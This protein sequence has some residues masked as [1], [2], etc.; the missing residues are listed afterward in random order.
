VFLGCFK[1]F[2]IFIGPTLQPCMHI[3]RRRRR[4]VPTCKFS[5]ERHSRYV[6]GSGQ[7]GMFMSMSICWQNAF[8]CYFVTLSV[9]CSCFYSENLWLIWRSSGTVWLV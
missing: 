9:F 8:F 5:F 6:T 7:S 1:T 3:L 4:Q 2:E